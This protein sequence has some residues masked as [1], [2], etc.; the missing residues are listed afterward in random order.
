MS[1]ALG[2]D[3]GSVR[4]GLALSDPT[5]AIAFPHKAI[6]FK[7]LPELVE[8]ISEL[9]TAK[10]ISTVIIGKPLRMSGEAGK[11]AEKSAIFAEMLG[12]AHPGI[13]IVLLDERLTSAEAERRI[14]EAGGKPSRNKGSVDAVAASIILRTWLERS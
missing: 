14:R 10:N 7:G 1:V 8:E 5:G 9:I 13:D 11:M 4:V 3:L 2:I 12:E 6:D